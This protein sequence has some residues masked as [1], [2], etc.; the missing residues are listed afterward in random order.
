MLVL[1]IESSCDETA[2]SVLE[3]K[4]KKNYIRSEIVLSQISRH[5][6]YGGVVPEISSREHIKNLDKI[7]RDAVLV[8]KRKVNELDAISATV[9]PGLLGG[10]LIGS[11]YAKALAMSLKKPFYAI[12]HLQGHALMPR[13]SHDVPYPFLVLLISGGHTQIILVKNVSK[14]EIWGETLDDAVGEAYDKTAQI[15]GLS[16]PGGPQIEKRARMSNG[17]KNYDFPRPMINKQ[18]LD[19]SFSGLKTAVRREVKSKKLTKKDVND[20][21]FDFQNCILDCLIDK[22]TKAVER[23]KKNY[24]T[25]LSLV[26]SGGVASNFFIRKAFKKFARKKCISLLIPAP[27]Y[28]VDNATMIA[29]VCIERIL[30][31]DCGDSVNE[32]VKPRWAV[33]KL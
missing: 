14:F 27:N 33:D 24:S 10:L 12:N 20:I 2:V 8:S 31:G 30:S 4:I 1:G 6:K 32:D 16:Y 13:F 22:T 25:K 18:N 26:V 5:K 15:L 21:S 17:R 9:G 7:V 28:C 19:F 11:N 23:F 3:R 29:W